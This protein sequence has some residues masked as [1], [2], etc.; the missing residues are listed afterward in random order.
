MITIHVEGMTCMG[1]V[2]SVERALK[3]ADP[4]AKIDIDLASG[5]LDVDGALDRAAV[6]AAVEATGFDVR[7]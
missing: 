3:Q 5:R 1:C 2:Q 4:T 7:D 6:E